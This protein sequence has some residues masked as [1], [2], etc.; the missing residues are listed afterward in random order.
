M[1]PLTKTDHRRCRHTKYDVLV[2]SR[3]HD[4]SAETWA[5]LAEVLY[6]REHPTGR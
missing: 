6:E 3:P 1:T 2:K 5:R 4:R